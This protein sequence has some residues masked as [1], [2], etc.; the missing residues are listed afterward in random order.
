MRTINFVLSFFF[1]LALFALGT[2]QTITVDGHVFPEGAAMHDGVQII[3]E[4]TAP[5]PLW[6]TTYSDAAGNFH[7][8]PGSPCIN[9]GGMFAIT[10]WLDTIY[11]PDVDWDGEHRP[12]GQVST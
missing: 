9:A 4:R 5:Y 6:D 3:F 2:A 12:M 1:V 11:A 10:P 7:L 8:L